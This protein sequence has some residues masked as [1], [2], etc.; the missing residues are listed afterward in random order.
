MQFNGTTKDLTNGFVAFNTDV[1]TTA[2]DIANNIAANVSA[3]NALGTSDPAWLPM[4]TVTTTGGEIKICGPET[5]GCEWNGANVD[6]TTTGGFEF[7]ALSSVK[8]LLGGACQTVS[9]WFKENIPAYGKIGNVLAGFAGNVA[10]ALIT[11]YVLNNASTGSISIPEIPPETKIAF[12]IK[13][14]KVRVPTGYNG[15]ART[16][17]MTYDAWNTAGRSWTVMWTNNPIWCLYDYITNPVYGCGSVLRMSSTQENLLLQDL[18]EL[19]SYCDDVLT[20]IDGN[21]QPRFSLNTVITS[22][23]REQ[24]LEQITSNF[25]GMYCWHNGGLRIR[26]DK[27]TT[28]VKL[29][30]TQA[31]T[32]NFDYAVVSSSNFM[33]KVNV[34]YVEPSNFYKEE[35]VQAKLLTGNTS[36]GEITRDYVYF[37]CTDA[38]QAIRQANWYLLTEKYN[39]VVVSYKANDDHFNLVPGDIV[40]FEDS[41]QRFG[42]RYSGRIISGTGTTVVVDAPITSVAGDLFSVMQAGGTVFQTTIASKTG[43]TITL[44]AAPASYAAN[45][46]FI[47]APLSQG[48]QYYRCVS[49]EETNTAEYNITLQVYR[50][51]KFTDTQNP[52]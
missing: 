42:Q 9:N 7:D 30:V 39:S 12:L 32:Q 35:V 43:T 3:K 34:T 52:V 8:T 21:P 10:G 40:E 50:T 22:G 45:A 2:T 49:K 14:L 13:G 23:T 25:R 24:I 16:G 47:A 27:E 5:K 41:T 19:A 1:A 31:N 4:Y 36:L 38:S 48:R 29:L 28:A 51:E 6:Y 18:F 46:V 20:D 37:G 11:N 17:M 44:A 26:A 15:S 33:N